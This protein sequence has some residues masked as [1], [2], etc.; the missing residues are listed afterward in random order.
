MVQ[1]GHMVLRGAVLRE[2]S[3]SP[4][5]KRERSLGWCSSVLHFTWLDKTR[6][7]KKFARVWNLNEL[8][9]LNCGA[10]RFGPNCLWYV[11][12][13]HRA[14]RKPLWIGVWR[15]FV[16]DFSGIFIATSDDLGPQ[17]AAKEGKSPNFTTSLG[18]WNI[19]FWADWGW[20]WE[21]SILIQNKNTETSM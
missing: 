9:I 20:Q 10:F 13:C 3:R 5:K 12:L 1:A 4:Q 7:L 21:V 8:F 6:I 16:A 15:F 18:R 19:I 17:K 14:I 2:R 11:F